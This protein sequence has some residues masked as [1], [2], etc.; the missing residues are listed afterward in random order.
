LA[1]VVA[2]IAVDAAPSRVFGLIRDQGQRERFL[3]D[4]WR[5]RRFLS[6]HHQGFGAAME[7]EASIGPRP[8]AQ[9]IQ[10]QVVMEDGADLRQVESPPTADNYVTTWTVRGRDGGSVV[11]LHTEFDYGGLI[12]EFFARRRLRGAYAQMLAR[13]KALAE[14][15]QRFQGA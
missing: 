9:V 5:F 8:T 10:V 11:F 13:L 3:P 1:Q 14:A 4:G 12:G 6:E 15:D 7:V 2:S